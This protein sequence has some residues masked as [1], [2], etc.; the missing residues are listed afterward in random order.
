LWGASLGVQG[1]SRAQD[2]LRVILSSPGVEAIVLPANEF[3]LSFAPKAFDEQGDLVDAKTICFLEE[4]FNNFV[5]MLNT[6]NGN[7]QTKVEWSATYDTVILGFGVAGATAARFAADAGAQVLLVD[8][9]P[10][11]H[12]GGNTRYAGQVVGTGVPM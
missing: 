8:A 6:I 3:L 2:N 1:T 11:G 5:Q 10:Y 12:E 4:C 7:A 9:A